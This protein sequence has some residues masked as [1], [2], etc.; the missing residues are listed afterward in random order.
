MLCFWSCSNHLIQDGRFLNYWPIKARPGVYLL[1]SPDALPEL[2][3]AS[4]RPI[5][6]PCTLCTFVTRNINRG[7]FAG[8]NPNPASLLCSLSLSP[9]RD[10]LLGKKK[11]LTKH[12]HGI[13]LFLLLFD[14]LCTSDA[15]VKE[16][17]DPR[18]LKTKQNRASLENQDNLTNTNNH[19]P[20]NYLHN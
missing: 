20:P 18:K 11:H 19:W 5:F 3:F 8:R 9:E 15:G 16:R 7:P 13:V 1:L 12:L 17:S 10:P 4:C 14:S 6:V 2:R